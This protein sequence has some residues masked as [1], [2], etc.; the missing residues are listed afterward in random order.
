VAVDIGNGGIVPHDADSVLANA[1]G[2]CKDHAVLFSAL[3]K[4]KGIPSE[5][6]LINLG[7]AYTLPGV[8][9][10]IPMNHAITWLPEFKTYA[11]TTAG[12]APF[13]ILPFDE[14]G[15]PVIHAVSSGSARRQTPVLAQGS[16]TLNWKTTAR[17]DK[18]GKVT[19][20]TAMTAM[21]PF[22]LSLRNVGLA[23]Q[24]SGAARFATAL[25]ER[26]GLFGTGGFD[27]PP[28][29]DIDGPYTL[30]ASF[31]Y[32]PK[33]EYLAGVRFEMVRGM[34]AR[35]FRWG[36]PHGFPIR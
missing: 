10:L 1:Y 13:G 34:W 14:Y 8:P 25:L 23:I 4:A 16:A 30:Q 7:N 28:P 15:K 12:T 27:V 32:G 19:G 2:D 6:V 22:S 20:N 18:D 29:T 36:F 9:T 35:A 24:G 21:G 5:T 31:S 17:L 11:D 3:L 26:Q 33:P